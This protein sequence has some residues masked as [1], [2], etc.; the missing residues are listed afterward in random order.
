MLSYTCPVGLGG[1]CRNP[2][3]NYVTMV[4]FRFGVQ[5]CCFVYTYILKNELFLFPCKNS[6]SFS[7]ISIYELNC[8]HVKLF[9]VV[10]INEK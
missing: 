10:V 9:V 1:C 7:W 3:L 4:I 8:V 5:I 6:H 2:S